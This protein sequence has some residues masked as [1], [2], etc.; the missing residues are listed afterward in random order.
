MNP[1]IMTYCVCACVPT[2][3]TQAEDSD[4]VQASQE[5]LEKH[6]KL[7]RV[8]EAMHAAWQAVGAARAKAF[9]A[10]CVAPHARKRPDHSSAN[11]ADASAAGKR[12]RCVTEV[13]AIILPDSMAQVLATVEGKV[14]KLL[15]VQNPAKKGSAAASI[16]VK[17]KATGKDVQSLVRCA[18]VSK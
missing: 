4:V 5:A 14:G 15:K 7:R 17:D 12:S 1:P 2:F 11:T 10:V 16:V 8:P 18:C 13:D 3:S 9:P 6:K